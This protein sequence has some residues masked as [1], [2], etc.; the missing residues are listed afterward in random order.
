MGDTASDMAHRNSFLRQLVSRTIL[1][2]ISPW[3]L[4]LQEATHDSSFNAWDP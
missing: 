4:H 2:Q 1:L 3:T